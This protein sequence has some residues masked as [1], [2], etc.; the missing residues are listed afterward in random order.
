MNANTKKTRN[1]GIITGF[2]TRKTAA[3]S[4]RKKKVIRKQT[5]ENKFI[6]K[7]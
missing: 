6:K 3:E 7:N 1:T 4:T 5:S 2:R